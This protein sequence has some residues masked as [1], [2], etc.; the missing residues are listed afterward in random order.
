MT[1]ADTGVNT[2]LSFLLGVSPTL[3]S[4][5]RPK[6]TWRRRYPDPGHPVGKGPLDFVVDF[7]VML[8]A[9]PWRERR[10]RRKQSKSD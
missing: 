3:C 7:V 8:I 6:R 5:S 2:A 10:R 1:F 9:D 4:V